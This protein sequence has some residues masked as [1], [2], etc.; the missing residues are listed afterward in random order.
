MAESECLEET[1]YEEPIGRGPPQE[2][3]QEVDLLSSK[4]EG[5]QQP[6]KGPKG[7]GLYPELDLMNSIKA[8]D[9]LM[10]SKPDQNGPQG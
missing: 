5:L 8:Y 2:Q 1:Q 7:K 6:N 9:P 4:A 3:P 10:P